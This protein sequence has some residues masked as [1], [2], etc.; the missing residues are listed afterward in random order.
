M[1][2]PAWDAAEVFKSEPSTHTFWEAIDYYL[3]Y[4]YVIS[5]PDYFVM[6]RPVSSHWPEKVIVNPIQDNGIELTGRHDMWHIHLMAGDTQTAIQEFPYRLDK[7]SF[8]RHNK[9]RTYQYD[10]FLRAILRHK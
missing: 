6:A 1:N 7:I 4:G 3:A 9:L 10:R 2:K 8:E 5:R